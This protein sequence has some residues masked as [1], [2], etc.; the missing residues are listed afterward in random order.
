MGLYPCIPLEVATPRPL[1]CA[2]VGAREAP[3]AIYFKNITLYFK[4]ITVYLKN[5]T[6][7]QNCPTYFLNTIS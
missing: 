5:I 2:C 7:T 3:V 4:N 6:V 1:T